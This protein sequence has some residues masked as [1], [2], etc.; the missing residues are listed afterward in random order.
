MNDEYEKKIDIFF[1][2]DLKKVKSPNIIEFGV[3]YGV[4]TK[5]F[6]QIC[7]END[8]FLN[9]I[10]ILDNS[11]VSS[12]DKW[13]FHCTRDDNFEYLDKVLPADVDLIY[14]DSFH[15]ANH[16]EKIFFHYFPLLKVGGVF[17]FDDISWLPYL[18]NKI[19]NNFN[20]E[21]NNQETF[22]KILEIQS[23]NEE[24]FDLYFSFV[25][26]GSA[27]IVKKKNIAL[28]KTKKLHTRKFSI[29]NYLRRLF[30]LFKS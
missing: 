24:I 26:S 16:I 21:I 22:E 4:S 15:N 29:K 9:S 28:I 1:M 2:E 3:R 8:G 27:K 10:D 23:Q 30:Y 14:L 19:R 25:G 20:C 7:E 17:I 6:I 18:K 5:K 11:D 12:S 13:N